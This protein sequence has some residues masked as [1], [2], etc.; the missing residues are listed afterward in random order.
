MLSEKSRCYL[1][2]S[3]DI[4]A[5]SILILGAPI[6]FIYELYFVSDHYQKVNGTGINCYYYG[7][8]IFCAVEVFWN[9]YYVTT[10]DNRTDTLVTTSTEELDV[11]SC[12]EC[13]MPRVPQSHH[14][15]ACNVCILRRDHHCW[16][17]GNCVGLHNQGNFV[18][19]S[20]YLWMAAVIQNIYNIQFVCDVLGCDLYSL[21]TVCL[22]HFP[23][24][25]KQYSLYCFFVNFMTFLGI[26]L[27]LMFTYL[28]WLQVI[29]LVTGLTRH[30]L[31]QRKID[32]RFPN[33]FDNI[34]T[35]L[36]HHW[37]LCWLLPPLNTSL[38]LTSKKTT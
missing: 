32:Y 29:Q 10:C 6:D 19:L 13:G 26:L 1:Q 7:V 17:A 22:P 31:K 36:G 20:M 35:A 5:F 18:M 12:E 25:I 38:K 8:L 11:E 33:M 37:Y 2:N 3:K 24:M 30:Q 21:L 27:L 4:A 15:K 23:V 9:L 14:C 16:F 28:F 34:V